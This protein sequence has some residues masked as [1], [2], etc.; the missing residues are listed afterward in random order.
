M[1]FESP[2]KVPSAYMTLNSALASVTLGLTAQTFRISRF[3]SGIFEN[4]TV[5]TLCSTLS[6]RK[7]VS[8]D[9]M[10]E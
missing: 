2:F 5:T 4:R 9:W 10:M 6:A 7:M 1:P 3:P 8:E